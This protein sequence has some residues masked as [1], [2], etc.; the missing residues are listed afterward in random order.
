MYRNVENAYTYR[1]GTRMC[2]VL[3]KQG[4]RFLRPDKLDEARQD[5]LYAYMMDSELCRIGI[6]PNE[7]E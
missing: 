7:I 3:A 6:G 4:Q 2:L 1:I 5:R